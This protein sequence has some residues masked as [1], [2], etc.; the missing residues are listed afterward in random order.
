MID[1]LKFNNYFLFEMSSVNGNLTGIDDVFIWVGEKNPKH[2]H[3]IKVSNVK[4]RYS[5]EDTFSIRLHDLTIDGNR[6]LDNK[7]L[8]KIN[9][10]IMKNKTLIEKFSNLE[11]TFYDFIKNIQKV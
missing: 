8:S 7:S 2:A 3:R 4:G 11:I 6:K 9:N 5:K 1:M 10:F